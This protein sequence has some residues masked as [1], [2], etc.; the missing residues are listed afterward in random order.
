MKALVRNWESKR[1]TVL[2]CKRT[3]APVSGRTVSGYGAK[4]PSEY[5]VKLRGRWRRVYVAC[6]GNASTHYV[7]KP[8]NWEFVIEG[9]QI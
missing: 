3:V 7:G 8:G 9:M 5:M 1:E 6:F 2:D 4:I